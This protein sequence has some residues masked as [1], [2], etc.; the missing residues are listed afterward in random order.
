MLAI[1]PFR[2]V[3][4]AT[5]GDADWLGLVWISLVTVFFLALGFAGFR[6]RDLAR[7]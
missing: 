4:N 5:A 6:R 1:S 2:H 3:P 7:R